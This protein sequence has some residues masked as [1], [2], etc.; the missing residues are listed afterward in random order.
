L[1][2]LSI[3]KTSFE[4]GAKIN[5]FCQKALKGQRKQRQDKSPRDLLVSTNYFTEAQKE[6]QS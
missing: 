6:T 1:A 4:I 2:A 3:A 5:L